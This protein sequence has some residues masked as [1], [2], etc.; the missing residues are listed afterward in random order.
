MV[1]W[2]KGWTPATVGEAREYLDTHER[3]GDPDIVTA[4]E[5]MIDVIEHRPGGGG[6]G[7][8]RAGALP[9][10]KPSLDQ[11]EEKGAD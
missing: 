7:A 9:V 1:E 11:L 3:D 10:V 8:G 5:A 6:P 2:K 4:C